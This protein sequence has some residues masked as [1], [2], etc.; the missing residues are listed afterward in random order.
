MWLSKNFLYERPYYVTG[1][2]N[3]TGSKEAP[4]FISTDRYISTWK[5]VNVEGFTPYESFVG[6]T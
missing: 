1:I 3:L 2:G 4:K 5:A 6:K